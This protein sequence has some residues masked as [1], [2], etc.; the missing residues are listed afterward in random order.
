MRVAA[1][2]LP[3]VLGKALANLPPYPGSILFVAGLNLT[4]ARHLPSSTLETLG[5]RTLRIHVRDAGIRFDFIWR[6]GIFHAAH[7]RGGVD[8]T[9][10]ASAYDFF[11][12]AR[13]H[14]DPDTLFFSRRLTMEGDTELGLWVKNTLDAIDLSVFSPSS[15]FAALPHRRGD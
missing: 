13:R 6:A 1:Y 14:E 9:I 3:A 12:L 2:Q 5:G 15:L 8:L 4:L 7:H 10:S 11:L